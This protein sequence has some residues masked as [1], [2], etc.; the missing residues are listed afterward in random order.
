ML[1]ARLALPAFFK[2]GREVAGYAATRVADR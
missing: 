1:W 2:R